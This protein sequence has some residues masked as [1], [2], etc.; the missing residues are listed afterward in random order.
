VLDEFLTTFH[1]QKAFSQY[2]LSFHNLTVIGTSFLRTQASD[3][4]PLQT[5]LFHLWVHNLYA[6]VINFHF[7]TMQI[8]I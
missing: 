8:K 2:K 1:V 6:L 5:K 4:H 7:Q 3:K